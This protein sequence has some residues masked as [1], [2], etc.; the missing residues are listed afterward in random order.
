VEV[1]VNR[2]VERLSRVYEALPPC[3]AF[4]LF[5]GSGDPRDMSR[6]QGLRTKWKQEYNTPGMNWDQL[7]VKWTDTEEQALKRAVRKAR[8]GIGFVAVK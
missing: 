1:S 4:I 5:S 3:T 6:L 7:S 2:L 8:E